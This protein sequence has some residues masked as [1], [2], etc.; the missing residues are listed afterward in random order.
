MA[1]HLKNYIH[2]LF[3]ILRCPTLS[4]LRWYKDAFTSRVML[5]NDSTKPFWKEK[6]INGLPN[7]FVHKIREVLS[8]PNGIIDYDNLIYV[9]II[10]TIQKECLKM[11]IDMKI[12]KHASKKKRKAKYEMR[13]FCE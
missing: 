3:S 4:D 13:N 12:S 2:D 8:N 9:D 11:C 6:F 1:H 10:I 5:G 7:L